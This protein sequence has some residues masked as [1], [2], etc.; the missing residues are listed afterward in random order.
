MYF[1]Q[2]PSISLSN[3]TILIV[4]FCHELNGTHPHNVIYQNPNPDVTIFEYREIRCNP[5]G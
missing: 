5:P 3:N 1:S 2:S 4:T